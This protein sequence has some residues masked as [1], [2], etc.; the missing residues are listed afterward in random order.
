MLLITILRL[1]RR[2][3]TTCFSPEGVLLTAE[4]AL[5]T[6]MRGHLFL[7]V[8]PCTFRAALV[9]LLGVSW[10]FDKFAV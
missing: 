2:L 7:F 4:Q 1:A 5:A 8:F 9:V 3:G 10:A 6:F